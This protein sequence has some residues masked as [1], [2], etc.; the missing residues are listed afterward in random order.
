[1]NNLSEQ[2]QQNLCIMF[3]YLKSQRVCMGK[4]ARRK[5]RKMKKAGLLILKPEK[6][7]TRQEIYRT[8]Y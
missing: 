5:Y 1:M 3:S 7:I 2:I 6:D 8:K 4:K